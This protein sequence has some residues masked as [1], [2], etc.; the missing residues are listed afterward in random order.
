MSVVSF[1]NQMRTSRLAILVRQVGSDI[2]ERADRHRK[3]PLVGAAILFIGAPVLLTG[4]LVIGRSLAY[5]AEGVWHG[6][7]ATYE[8]ISAQIEQ[9]SRDQARTNLQ[10]TLALKVCANA[11]PGCL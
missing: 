2:A 1:T 7:K 6:A 10:D 4:E 9:S 3:S 5:G 8:A 11:P